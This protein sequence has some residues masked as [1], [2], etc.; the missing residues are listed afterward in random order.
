MVRVKTLK[1]ITAAMAVILVM[2]MST[3]DGDLRV[4]VPLFMV[5][6]GWITLIFYANGY[7]TCGDCRNKNRC[8][9]RSRN[10][11]CRDFKKKENKDGTHDKG[12]RRSKGSEGP[13]QRRTDEAG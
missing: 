6:A 1:V 10:Y 3:F 12:D 8:M 7:L 4:W 13:D 9:E 2:C 11:P 5:S